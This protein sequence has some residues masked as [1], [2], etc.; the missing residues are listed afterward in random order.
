MAKTHRIAVLAGDGIGPE[1]M[2]QAIRV[3]EAVAAKEGISFDW[4]PAKVG[5]AA[6]DEFQHPLPES[7]VETCKSAEA[8][9]FGS[10]GTV[11]IVEARKAHGIAVEKSAI[12][13]PGG[14]L[15]HVGDH[16]VTVQLHTDVTAH[17]TVGVLGDTSQG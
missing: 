6:Y 1:V 14:P 10:V 11:D 9:L 5:G 16:P 15:K 4:A 7:T 3:L 2:D 8:I 17:V 12:R 13:L